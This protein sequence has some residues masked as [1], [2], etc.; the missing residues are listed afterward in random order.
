M[1]QEVSEDGLSINLFIYLVPGFMDG[2]A[3]SLLLQDDRTTHARNAQN[4]LFH[5]HRDHHDHR[6]Y[7]GGIVR[8]ADLD[9]FFGDV[10][11][12]YCAKGLH[13]I[14]ATRALTIV[15]VSG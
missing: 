2:D 6:V 15:Y 5:D 13:A 14:I 3:E 9:K 7:T 10:Y 11:D 4:G 12:Y 1:K 8:P